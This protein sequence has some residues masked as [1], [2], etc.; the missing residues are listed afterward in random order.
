MKSLVLYES[1]YGNTQKVA[2]V[3]AEV[4]GA[5][6]A[7]V[8]NFQP[9][10]LEEVDLLVVGSP[11]HGWQPSADTAQLLTHLDRETLK[12]KYVAAFDTGFKSM[13]SGNAASKIMKKLE[14]AGAKELIPTQKFVVVQAEGPLAP[15]EM[16]RAAEWAGNLKASYEHIVSPATHFAG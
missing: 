3:V 10:M 13:L 1:K 15:G 11:I 5:E 9:A 4:L 7:E 2:E 12:G 6:I 8:S 16:E 14:R